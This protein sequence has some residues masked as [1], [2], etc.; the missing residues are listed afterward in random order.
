MEVERLMKALL[1]RLDEDEVVEEEA[2]R[3]FNEE[4]KTL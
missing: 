3:E 1:P 4:G 2:E